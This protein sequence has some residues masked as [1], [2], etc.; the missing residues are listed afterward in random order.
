MALDWHLKD[1]KIEFNNI[2]EGCIGKKDI[3]EKLIYEGDIVKFWYLNQYL[4]GIVIWSTIYNGYFIMTLSNGYK[5]IENG[6]SV[7]IIGDIH[8]DLNIYSDLKL[9]MENNL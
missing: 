8:H 2:V 7:K 5:Q 3:Y 1:D 9:M 4:Y 6:K